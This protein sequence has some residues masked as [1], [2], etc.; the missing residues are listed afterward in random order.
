MAGALEGDV[1]IGPNAEEHRGLLS[2]KYP[3]EHGYVNDWADMERV[4]QYVY[5]K[6]QLNTFAE[7]VLCC[8]LCDLLS[9]TTLTVFYF[10][11]IAPCSADGSSTEPTP[12][13]GEGC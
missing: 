3:M 5:S 12:Q 8:N 13:Q 6:E 2:L 4:W 11:Q 1:F 10:P 9:C 7:E